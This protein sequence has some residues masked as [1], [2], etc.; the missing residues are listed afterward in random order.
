[1]KTCSKCKETKPLS[2]FYKHKKRKDGLNCWC[3]GCV[4]LHQKE[5]H[6]SEKYKEY[7]KE[8]QKSDKRREYLKEYYKS[9]KYKEYQKSEKYKE[10][11][12]SDNHRKAEIKTYFKK[13]QGIELPQQIIETKLII[14]KIKKLKV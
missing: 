7:Q 4:K 9:E 5:Y 13:A 8:Y 6:K 3:K 14:N 10:Y 12:K 2:E 1:M 11:F